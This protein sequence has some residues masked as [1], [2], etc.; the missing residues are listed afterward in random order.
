MA[1]S[2][3]LVLC[4]LSL[5]APA[6][7]AGTPR[8][9]ILHDSTDDGYTYAGNLNQ[10]AWMLLEEE[11][12]TQVHKNGKIR[13]VQD[14]E[15]LYETLGG[16]GYSTAHDYDALNPLMYRFLKPGNYSVH[17][18]V[19]VSSGVSLSAHFN[20]TIV[21]R[22]DLIEASLVAV[23]AFP[24]RASVGSLTNFKFQLQTKNGT[25]LD[26]T[27]ALFEIRE[28]ASKW[29]VFR[30]KLHTH[31]A[32]M[33]ASFA[34][35][36]PGAYT[37]RVIGWQAYPEP[38]APAF[39]PVAT[40][41]N[42]E[43]QDAGTPTAAAPGFRAQPGSDYLLL[44][45]YDP[46]P[47]GPNYDGMPV[48][49]PYGNVR[50]NLI[51]YDPIGKRVLPHVDFEATLLDAAGNV[52]YR[53]KTL[54]EYDGHHEVITAPGLVGDYRLQVVATRDAWRAAKELSFRVAPPTYVVPGL[55]TSTPP[56]IIAPCAG[57]VS[58]AASGL[59]KAVWNSMARVDFS[60][61]IATGEPCMHSEIEIQ[62]GGTS[63]LGVPFLI[64]KLHTHSDGKFS[65]AMRPQAGGVQHIVLDAETLDGE[66][67]VSFSPALW[68]FDAGRDLPTSPVS[69]PL[70]VATGRMPA[71]D[72]V[73]LAVAVLAAA[74]IIARRR[75]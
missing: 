51:A 60:A 71:F 3:L 15:V 21:E 36:K 43:V 17:A 13:L 53:S 59:D 23:G 35:L 72:V 2:F 63:P 66:P 5:L 56:R 55:A 68:Q 64:N 67:S 45:T 49:G 14:G 75:A 9:F 58:L 18:E 46:A 33:E 44:H 52:L 12:K 20:G 69:L 40:T 11:G 39:L 32:P 4:L 22:D 62:W 73:L 24:A 16:S 70:A 10:F 57:P 6:A 34:F 19:N 74:A 25:L 65:V 38:D 7:A 1:R 31:S 41:W 37:V 48:V 28:S 8:V 47:A 27:D 50:L 61:R 29:L 42:L 54:H 30:T 26:H